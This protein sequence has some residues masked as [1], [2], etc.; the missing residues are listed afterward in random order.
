MD[1]LEN[2]FRDQLQLEGMTAQANSLL[3]DANSILN[4][5]SKQIRNN[6][7][8]GNKNVQF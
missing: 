1:V 2:R 5:F 4:N 8:K 6:R 3:S 7:I